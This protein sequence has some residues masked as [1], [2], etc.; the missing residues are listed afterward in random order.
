MKIKK[1]TYKES[2]EEN[3]TYWCMEIGSRFEEINQ[4]AVKEFIKIFEEKKIINKNI[5]DIGSGDG[6]A[7]NE[8]IKNGFKV[9]ALDINMEKLGRIQNANAVCADALTYIENQKY[10]NNVFTHHSLEHMISADQIIKK[11]SEKMT[12]NCLYYAT[13]PAGD[14]LHS[15]H[16]VVFESP[17]EILPPMFEPILLKERE[18][19]GEKEYVCVAIKI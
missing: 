19:F 11:I 1:I 17:I 13:V 16:H 7:T 8:F 18:R 6:A 14:Y 12:P 15:V 4:D 9:T 2:I 10:L 5:L 3:L